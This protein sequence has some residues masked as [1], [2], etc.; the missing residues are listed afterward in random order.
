MLMANGNSDVFQHRRS[1]ARAEH[2]LVKYL[3]RAGRHDEA[4]RRVLRLFRTTRKWQDKEP[5]LVAGLMNLAVRGVAF[6]GLN[7]ILRN[8]KSLSP[9]L[10]AEI[11][12]EL[13]RQEQIKRVIPWLIQTG[14][15]LGCDFYEQGPWTRIPFGDLFAKEGQMTTLQFAHRLQLTADKPYLEVWNEIQ[16]LTSEVKEA[17][18]T[19]LG[20]IIY[21]GAEGL[22]ASETMG[23]RA[24]E[25][26]VARVRCLRV[27]NALASR[28]DFDA[29]ISSL[30]IPKESLVDPFNGK[31]LRI[32]KTPN[33]PIIYS[34]GDDLTDNDG[35]VNYPGQ[36]DV[37]TAP[38]PSKSESQ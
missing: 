22:L 17:R 38:I 31:P 6:E 12:E 14:A 24:F 1:V 2:E 10:H 19:P 35:N 16:S 25:R 9:A 13:G 8:G 28:G 7:A 32:K 30:G 5:F 27:L 23:R 3:L 4:A 20:A 29:N 37:G 26:T 36:A 18:G 34:V 33:G 11:D 21:F 15:V